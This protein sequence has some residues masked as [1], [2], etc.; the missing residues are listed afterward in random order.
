MSNTSV[1][2]AVAPGENGSPPIKVGVTRISRAIPGGPSVTIEFGEARADLLA[3]NLDALS[4]SEI[5][6]LSRT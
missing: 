1:R 4:D 3:V 2:Y 6:R 5:V